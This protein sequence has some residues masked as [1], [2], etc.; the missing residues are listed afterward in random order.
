MIEIAE[1]QDKA[2]LSLEQSWHETTKGLAAF[3]GE[4]R[5]FISQN[6]RFISSQAEVTEGAANLTRAGFDTT[7]SMRDLNIA[8]DLSTLKHI[9]LAEAINTVIKAEGGRFRGLVDL[10]ISIK[11]VT[12]GNVDQ[13]ASEK[14]IAEAMD[15]LALKTNG[16]REAQTKME[17]SSHELSNRWQT[18]SETHGPRLLEALSKILEGANALWD[19]LDR[20]GK[21]DKWWKGFNDGI[22]KMANGAGLQQLGETIRAIVAAVQWLNDPKNYSNVPAP[23]AG[24]AAGR[25]ASGGPVLPNSIYTVG[26]AGPETLVMGPNGGMVIPN[27]GG[28][29]PQRLTLPEAR[30]MVALL[31]VIAKNTGSSPSFSTSAYGR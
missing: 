28:G 19:A 31:A 23:S 29:G 25:R 24:Q 1:Q 17:Q 16:G 9:P 8:L 2:N 20:F 15:E 3:K 5:D 30:D 13:V 14:R 21:D 22:I 11:G 10:G 18:I 6:S 26:E 27:S 4:I 12:A 7:K